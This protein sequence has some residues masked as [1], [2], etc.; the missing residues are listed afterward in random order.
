ML[1]RPLAIIGLFLWGC[2]AQAAPTTLQC[3]G[4][5]PRYAVMVIVVYDADAGTVR[6]TNGGPFSISLASG[7]WK[8]GNTWNYDGPRGTTITRTEWVKITNDWISWGDKEETIKNPYGAIGPGVLRSIYAINR[9]SRVLY[10]GLTSDGSTPR[11]DE[12]AAITCQPA[13][14]L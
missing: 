1:R 7:T 9:Q 13:S 2:A 10:T 12:E 3:Q 5:E 14:R 6:V 11:A 4:Q 8:N